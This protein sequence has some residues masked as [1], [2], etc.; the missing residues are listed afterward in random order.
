MK[1][2]KLLLF[3]LSIGLSLSTS[4]GIT[5]ERGEKP[6]SS[7]N[8]INFNPKEVTPPYLNFSPKEIRVAGNYVYIASGLNGLNIFDISKPEKTHWIK[9]VRES[10]HVSDVALS[11]NYAYALG[12]DLKI[13]D[14]SK[15]KNAHIV[16]TIE[17]PGRPMNGESVDISGGYA[18]ATT[19]FFDETGKRFTGIT[20]F[21]VDP[22]ESA[23]IVNSV[24]IDGETKK[25]RIFNKYA[26]VTWVKDNHGVEKPSYGIAMIDINSPEKA[27]IIKSI[28]IPDKANN[29]DISNGYAFVA[30]EDSCLRI[31]N[32]KSAKLVKVLKSNESV[33]D[34]NVSGNYA[35]LMVDGDEVRIIDISDLKNPKVIKKVKVNPYIHNFEMSGGYAYV[36][37]KGLQ[38]LDIEPLK[39]THVVKSIETFNNAEDLIISNGYA[40]VSSTNDFQI[41]KIDP[42]KS[43]R[44]VRTIPV[45]QI[46]FQVANGYAYLTSYDDGLWIIALNPPEKARVVKKIVTPSDALDVRISGGYAYV[47]YAGIGDESKP[48]EGLAIIDIKSPEKA[49]LIKS[50][51]MPHI[52]GNFRISKGYAFLDCGQNLTIIDIDPPQNAKI[53][54]TVSKKGKLSEV[55]DGYAYFVSFS[56]QILDIDPPEKSHPVKSIELSGQVDMTYTWNGYL[57]VPVSIYKYGH[58][59]TLYIFDITPPE[60][61]H[62]I[63]EIDT[64]TGCYQMHFL[65]GYAITS[66]ED[67]MFY[68][69]DIDPPE[70]AHLETSFRSS[71]NTHGFDIWNGYV[72]I[73]DDQI[74]LEIFDLW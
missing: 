14:I 20:I 70:S 68:I 21:D 9:A 32:I 6:G 23:K 25:V 34:V 18:Y 53:V 66:A 27:H 41:V 17:R 69:F 46:N 22:V 56:I 5:A 60:S 10:G 33:E 71:Y 16:K 36:I 73:P 61:A 58:K 39:E 50:I 57:L 26:Y 1:I 45:R 15:P 13:L 35:F 63:K 42:V 48:G 64:K 31:F 2:L 67:G 55:S 59:P 52:Q 65:N 40:Y 19:N 12:D 62:I 54:A 37:G 47:V 44:I 24:A 51:E 38:V 49:H 7:G 29:L 74:G 3:L 28:S 30:E 4:D 11:G 8:E 72:F 43:S